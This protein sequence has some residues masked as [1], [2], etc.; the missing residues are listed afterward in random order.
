VPAL[1]SERLASQLLAAFD[2][3]LELALDAFFTNGGL[4]DMADGTPPT[5]T[6]K[7]AAIFDRYKDASGEKIDVEGTQRLCEDLS[8]A[9]TDV[10]LLV[11]AWQMQ[12]KVVLEF[13]R[14][15]FTQGMAALGCDSIDALKTK[16]PRL[17]ASIDDPEEFRSFYQYAFDYARSSEPGQKSLALDTAVEMWRLLLTG[18]FALIEQWITFLNE[19]H[20]HAIPRD[21]WALLLE[22]STQVRADLS[23]YDEDGAWPV[24]LD[25]FV[26][27]ARP[28]LISRED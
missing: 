28:K 21:T 1:C 22:F 16:L 5:D 25:D 8:I 24:L 19:Q 14:E 3:N 17:R 7:I 27:W 15:E 4:G 26:A 10:V 18:R 23:D 6:S 13:T 2:W 9:P 11:L 20:K 12:A